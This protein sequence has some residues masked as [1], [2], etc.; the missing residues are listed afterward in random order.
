MKP[1]GEGASIATRASGQALR[2]ILL[3]GVTALSIEAVCQVF[4]RVQRGRWIFQVPPP[5]HAGLF[6]K[7]PYL[8]GV[9]RPGVTRTRR[10][11]T[12][13]HNSHGFRG[14]EFA[15]VKPPGVTRVL[16]IGGSSTYGVGV[17]DQDTW[18]YLLGRELGP[19][20]EVINLGVP[21]YSTVENLI[22]TAFWASDLSADVAIY[23]VGWN[24]LQSMFV[25]DLK[26]DYSDFHAPYQIINLA[27]SPHQRRRS[28]ATPYF[29]ETWIWPSAFVASPVGNDDKLTAKID[30]RALELYRRNLTL[31]VAI[32]RT[33]GLRPILVPQVLNVDLLTADEP[34]GWVPFVKD[35]DLGHA[36]AVYDQ[37]MRDVAAA[38]SAEFVAGL[39][40]EKLTPDDFV[41]VGHFSPQGDAKLARLLARTI[42]GEASVP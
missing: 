3:L 6:E 36:M 5:L 38:S 10:N 28:F 25:K 26:P 15:P 20:Y 19:G 24:D 30:P 41:D 4:F 9:G 37:A 29:L 23:M 21:G 2:L 31:I 33:L 12:I 18:P 42:R 32:S 8:V 7:H 35:K 11:V 14:P 1:S 34:Y 13:T 17:S 40:D 27:L 16:A 22:Q 39:L